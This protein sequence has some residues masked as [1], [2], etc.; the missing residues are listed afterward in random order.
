[1][2]YLNFQDQLQKTAELYLSI[3]EGKPKALL[4]MN[5]LKLK[6]LI[7]AIH[8][9]GYFDKVNYIHQIHLQKGMSK[10]GID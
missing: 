7:T 2:L 6:E 1:M 9:S 8:N 4:G 10:F 5:C 3:V